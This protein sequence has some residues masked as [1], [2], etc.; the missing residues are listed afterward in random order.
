LP[1][2]LNESW[3]QPILVADLEDK[4]IS[5]GN[6]FQKRHEASEEFVH[7]RKRLLIEISELQQ[8]RPQF[9]A[10]AIHGLQKIAKI[11]VAVHQRFFV[12]NDLRNFGRKTNSRGRLLIQAL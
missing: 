3:H 12:R 11:L 8:Q 9:F 2:R 5:L 6:F 7:A 10:E 4:A 1:Q